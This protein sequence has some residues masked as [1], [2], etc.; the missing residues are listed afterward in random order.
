MVKFVK[1][2]TLISFVLC[3]YSVDVLCV[4]S[5]CKGNPIITP[6]FN[7]GLTTLTLLN[8]AGVAREQPLGQPLQGWRCVDVTYP[9]LKLGVIHGKL[10]RSDSCLAREL[11]DKKQLNSY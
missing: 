6:S 7:W 4:S 10:L 2:F 1:S 9:Q 3:N 11:N 8:P 5:P